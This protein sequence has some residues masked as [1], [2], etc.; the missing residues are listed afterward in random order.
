MSREQSFPEDTALYFDQQ[1]NRVRNSALREHTIY[2]AFAKI[3][4]R[5]SDHTSVTFP[6]QVEHIQ[7]VDE[8]QRKT[9]MGTIAIHM[10]LLDEDLTPM[11]SQPFEAV[12][13][14]GMWHV[15]TPIPVSEFNVKP[16][17]LG[18]FLIAMPDDPQ[19]SKFIDTDDKNDPRSIPF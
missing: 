3:D 15:N 11:I 8:P 5:T 13:Q 12:V 1:R 10:V 2:T 9:F 6:V 14:E 18:Y 17:K 4:D 19:M 7:P 16:V